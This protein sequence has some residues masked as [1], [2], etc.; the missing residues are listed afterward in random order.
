M[1]VIHCHELVILLLRYL[2]AYSLTVDDGGH[3]VLAF[4][5]R[6]L[7]SYLTNS[8][9]SA[10][11]AFTEPSLALVQ[12]LPI[13]NT[14]FIVHRF[15]LHLQWLYGRLQLHLAVQ[16]L[17][18]LWTQTDMDALLAVEHIHRYLVCEII[19]DDI[20]Q[21]LQSLGYRHLLDGIVG[22]CLQFIVGQVIHH[23]TFGAF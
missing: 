1:V 17:L 13:H 5:L 2:V 7:H 10:M 9:F 23:I 3:A 4:L 11:L 14:Y 18:H 21:Y 20:V 19:L 15:L 6:W 16:L 8:Y 22:Q 12:V